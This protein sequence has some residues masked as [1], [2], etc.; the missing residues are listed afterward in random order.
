MNR[1]LLIL[2]LALNCLSCSLQLRPSIRVD[3]EG[4][5]TSQISDV[6][7]KKWMVAPEKFVK[8][9]IEDIFTRQSNGSQISSVL[10]ERIGFT[11]I[12]GPL[13][14]VYH[15]FLNYKISNGSTD[16][17]AE[18]VKEVRFKIGITSLNPITVSVTVNR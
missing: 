14:C 8:Q 10:A 12:D 2:T 11:C 4:L 6:I 15:G 13:T 7:T 1:T 5:G 16:L 3:I 9:E 18:T 17:Q